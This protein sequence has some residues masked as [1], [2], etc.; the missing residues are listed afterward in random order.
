MRFGVIL[1]CLSVFMIIKAL[2]Q[3]NCKIS[4]LLIYEYGQLLNTFWEACSLKNFL[5]HLTYILCI[6]HLF[7]CILLSI[8]QVEPGSSDCKLKFALYRLNGWLWKKAPHA[9]KLQMPEWV[10]L[11]T[12]KSA[13]ER[14]RVRNKKKARRNV[15]RPLSITLTPAVQHGGVWDGWSPKCK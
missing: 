9:A 5:L 13:R 6:H 15:S 2:M 14:E 7:T 1:Y 3:N 12:C 11:H 4:Q 10:C 8:K